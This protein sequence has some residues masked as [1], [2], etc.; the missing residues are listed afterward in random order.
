MFEISSMFLYR[1]PIC[2]SEAWKNLNT[3][4]SVGPLV[5]EHD[6]KSGKISVIET[7][8]AGVCVGKEVKWGVE[9]GRGLATPSHLFATNC[10]SASFVLFFSYF[11]FLSLCFF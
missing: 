10:D 4:L 6:L 11:S 1:K 3:W 7:F 2:L 5:H 8:S 9:C